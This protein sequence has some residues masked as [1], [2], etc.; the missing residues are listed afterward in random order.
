MNHVWRKLFTYDTSIESILYKKIYYYL[1]I[2][3]AAPIN[4]FLKTVIL[5]LFKAATLYN[6][7]N[8]LTTIFFMVTLKGYYKLLL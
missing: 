2:L 5:V 1:R 3:M 4:W 6:V 7:T 8:I